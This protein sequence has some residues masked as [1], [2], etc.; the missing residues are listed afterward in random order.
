MCFVFKFR[1]ALLSRAPRFVLLIANDFGS[2]HVK[3]IHF[4]LIPFFSGD[5]YFFG[6]LNTN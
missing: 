1:C 5:A 4:I 3:N 2:E 6:N